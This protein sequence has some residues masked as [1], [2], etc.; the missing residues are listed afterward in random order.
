LAINGVFS[1]IQFVICYVCNVLCCWCGGLCLG[2]DSK[3]CTWSGAQLFCC[4]SY[5]CLGGW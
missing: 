4:R 1:G 3:A 2:P 5:R